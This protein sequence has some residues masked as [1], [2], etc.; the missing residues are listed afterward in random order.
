MRI[1]KKDRETNSRRRRVAPA[2]AVDD[3]LPGVLR[4]RSRAW[5]WHTARCAA[6]VFAVYIVYSNSFESGFVLD[7]QVV[8]KLDPRM[9]DASLNNL[10]LIWSKD[11]W[12]PRQNTTAY[13]P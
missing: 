13:R 9:Q 7:N 6:L 3:Q 11:Y 8:L 10:K 1:K 12:W 4:P 5:I 2:P